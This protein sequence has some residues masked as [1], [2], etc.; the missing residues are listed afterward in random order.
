MSLL[1]RVLLVL[2]AT[3]SLTL[4][5]QSPYYIADGARVP[6]EPDPASL[7]L[8]VAPG[9]LA[10]VAQTVE[11]RADVASVERHPYHDRLIVRLD[12]ALT[13][14]AS[15]WAA[16]LG[17]APGALRSAVN[18]FTTPGGAELWLTHDVVFQP[19]AGVVSGSLQ[20]LLDRY[21]ARLSRNRFGTLVAEVSDPM[22]GLELGNALE[23]SGL[24]RFAHTDFYAPIER[25]D[26]PLYPEQFQLNNTGQVI[27]GFTGAFD[28]DCNAPEAWTVSL[29]SASVVVAV[30]DDGVEAH[31]DLETGGGASRVLSG[32][33]PATGGNGAP[34]S[35]GAHGQ[36]CT[37]IIAASHNGI[38]VQGVAPNVQ[39]LPINIFAGGETTQDLA[40]AFTY[41]K[42]NGADVISNSWGYVSS[43]GLNYSN[44]TS[45]I[46]DAASNGRGGL[47]C[48]IAFSSGNGYG[49]CVS[50]PAYLPSVLAVG[51][52]TNQGNLSAY[53][54]QG[55]NLDIVAPSN[56]APGQAGAGVRT[57]DRMGFSGYSSG[58]YT[59]GFGGTSAACPVVAGVAA[60]VVS[61]NPGASGSAI[62]GILTSTATDMGTPGFDNTFGFGRVNAA[63]A[64]SVTPAPTVSVSGTVQDASGNP[65]AGALVRYEGPSGP[66]EAT[67]DGSGNYALSG[68]VDGQFYG[69][70]AGRWGYLPT[71]DATVALDGSSRTTT[72]PAG[73]GDDFDLDLGWTV[74][75]TASTG[76]WVR[77]IPIGTDFSGV[78]CNPG[79]DA[80]DLGSRAYMT[81]NGGGAAGTDDVDGGNTVLTSPAF[82]LTG[83]SDPWVR[84]SQWF[85]NDGGSGTPDDVLSVR[86]SNGSTTVDLLNTGGSGITSTGWTRELARVSDFLTPTANMRFIVETADGSTGHLVEAAVDR[87][88]VFDST[89]T[90]AVCTTAP[91]G[92]NATVGATGVT[93]T[94]NSLAAD[95]AVSYTVSGRRAGGGSFRTLPAIAEPS[96]TAFVNQNKLR[97][98]WTYEFKVQ[99]TCAGGVTGPESAL[100][101]FTWPGLRAEREI[102]ATLFPNPAT[103]RATLQFE[104][105]GGEAR[106]RLL[107]ATGRV[108]WSDVRDWNTG[109]AVLDVPVDALPSGAY[110]LT[111]EQG[112]SREAHALT[113]VR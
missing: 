105:R 29:G 44:L 106:V 5:A 28:V 83:Y 62:H 60:L 57:T 49:T 53:S 13:G 46:N 108:R 77:D 78:P 25:H 22:Q 75:G 84:W 67:T 27:D 81:G 74:S 37:G 36:S 47:G 110:W 30:I 48:A 95:G 107:D 80:V 71:Y 21:G 24:V 103:E 26:D 92:L 12:A 33:T 58:N 69:I 98:G 104:A 4:S 90:T 18:G 86:L 2:C 32:F 94:W 85:F 20:P 97:A 40:D 54:N 100:G 38:G 73:Y 66:F 99:A 109:P 111:V 8:H 82:D 96:T 64:L 61:E 6:L 76:Q 10:Y 3:G 31:E 88:L 101:S 16:Q 52:I 9:E 59:N 42:N 7:A 63:A 23:A 102:S 50:Y 45:A 55:P 19:R 41:A 65:V 56:A 79:T 39:I 14:E 87:F 11:A 15:D 51:A 72:L 89:A 17:L 93:I 112:A 1:T 35:G 68:L 34:L 70:F 43:C 91:T 113:V